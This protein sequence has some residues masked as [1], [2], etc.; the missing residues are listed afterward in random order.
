[1]SW[2]EIVSI[3]TRVSGATAEM[4]RVASTPPIPGMFRS[5][6]TTSGLR[7][8]T[9]LTAS[10]PVAASPTSDDALLLEQVAEAGAE[11]IVVVDD[12]HTERIGLPLLGCLQHFAQLSAPSWEREV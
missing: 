3:T 5:M 10:A 7:S 11:Q 6:T 8:R 12:Q 2:S 4:W 9:S 1:M